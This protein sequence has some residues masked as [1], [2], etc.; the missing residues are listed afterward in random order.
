VAG[1]LVLVAVLRRLRPPAADALEEV[2]DLE[3]EYAEAER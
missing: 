1:L 3:E 2:E